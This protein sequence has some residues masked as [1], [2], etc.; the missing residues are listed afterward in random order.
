MSDHVAGHLRAERPVIQGHCDERV[1]RRG[2]AEAHR[3]D[4]HWVRGERR[5]VWARAGRLL[6]GNTEARVRRVPVRHH[7][8]SQEVHGQHSF[9]DASPAQVI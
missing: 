8:G 5:C 2:H 1:L 3:P 4:V 6:L 9:G 7:R